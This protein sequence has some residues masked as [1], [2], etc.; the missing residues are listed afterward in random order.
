LV[1]K[2]LVSDIVKKKFK[3]KQAK[4]AQSAPPKGQAK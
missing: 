1:I 4:S 2:H 3:T